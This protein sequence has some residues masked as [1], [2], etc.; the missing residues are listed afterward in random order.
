MKKILFLLLTLPLLFFSSC[1]SDDDDIDYNLIEGSWGLVHSEGYNN[2]DP[3][4]P[5][6]WNYDCNPLNPSSYDDEKFDIVRTE[7]NKYYLESYYYN[8]YSKKWVKDDSYSVSINGNNITPITTDEEYENVSVKILDITSTNLT[9][10][11]K[12]GS[13]YYLKEI[14]KRL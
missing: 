7:G 6:D 3:S 10:E 8:T 4:D 12:Q 14:H 5:F 9:I 13:V 2:E 1:S 11:V